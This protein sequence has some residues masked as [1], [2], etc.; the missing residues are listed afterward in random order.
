MRGRDRG[1]LR[2]R[3]VF[4]GVVIGACD[5]ATFAIFFADFFADVFATF[6]A[7]FECALSARADAFL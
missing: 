1:T 3:D 6:L 7:A 4:L 5:L 2:E